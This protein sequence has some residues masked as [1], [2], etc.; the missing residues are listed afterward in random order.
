MVESSS[1]SSFYDSIRP[2]ADV[3]R[4]GS[5]KPDS[6]ST[7]PVTKYPTGNGHAEEKQLREKTGKHGV[8]GNEE[9]QPAVGAAAAT[10]PPSANLPA[11]APDGE[12]STALDLGK[13]LNLAMRF[14]RN[15]KD[16]LLS[17][18]SNLLLV[19]VPVGIAAQ[20]ANLNP[21]LV[22]TMN[23]LAIIPLAGLL[24]HATEAVACTLGDTIGAL[25]NVTFGNAV[26]LIIFIIA[27]VK[28][29]IRIVQASL[30]GSILA[31]LLLILGMS[32][33]F[34][35]LR[36]REQI[37]NS[38]V[39]QMSAC[40]LSLSVT[41]LLLPTAFHAVF[42]TDNQSQADAA[43]L[44]LSRGSSVI[45][46]LVYVLYLLF[47]LKSHAY[48]YEST[49][50]HVIDEES[51][52][53]VLAE[54][55]NSSSSSDSSSCSDDSEGSSGSHTT[56]KRIKR[57]LR[58]RGRRKSSASSKDTPSIPSTL[59][60]PSNISGPVSSAEDG[61]INQLGVIASGDEADDD[62]TPAHF[63][64]FGS[65]I[66]RRDFGSPN[67][68][69][70]VPGQ[71]TVKKSKKESKKKRR[72]RKGTSPEPDDKHAA[73]E[74]ITVPPSP[75]VTFVQETQCQPNDAP[76]RQFNIRT[77][78]SV[79]PTMPKVLSSTVFSTT[80]PTRTA[81]APSIPAVP[82]APYGLRRTSSLPDRLNRSQ[83]VPAGHSPL[84]HATSVD[85]S[86]DFINTD[87]NK[88]KKPHM[89]RTAAIVLLLIVTGLVALCAEFLVGSINYMVATTNIS[90]VFIGLILLP[91][92]GNAAE[93]VTAVT[94]ATK[95]KMDLAI[96]V[97]VGSSIQV[98]VLRALVLD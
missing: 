41:S 40:L 7:H 91:I 62:D 11:A 97:A 32:F 4:L 81:V 16:A 93:H 60:T 76:R 92:V 20:F 39:T 89:S 59:R 27:L 34:G 69:L 51:R 10:L 78:S 53:G 84:Q 57:A 18:W 31:N 6:A 9:A 23:A 79:R 28:D 38:T 35:G 30:V 72:S 88:N 21:V 44:Q 71:R 25:L 26:E 1:T 61:Q 80:N 19:F 43:V 73:E 52:P 82:R 50:Q 45:L 55:L 8:L 75:R 87:D 74:R 58:R 5:Q 2:I 95:N 65:R 67:G 24:A 64:G 94:V 12:T 54:M 48:M 98:S 96:G 86:E 46:L 68:D 90:E 37:Y 33:L 22:F 47:Q 36:F 17:N 56:A 14:Y 66:H 49:P 83:S 3:F 13:K 70:A 29:E 85:A 15:A 42:S 77:L 63:G